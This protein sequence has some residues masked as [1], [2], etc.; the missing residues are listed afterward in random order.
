MPLKQEELGVLLLSI[1]Y[2]SPANDKIF[3]LLF[4]DEITA[5]IA[6]AQLTGFSPVPCYEFR[7]FYN[8]ELPVPIGTPQHRALLRRFGCMWRWEEAEDAQQE[9]A[10][11]LREG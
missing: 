8:H 4:D 3:E 2:P 1:K 10:W 11:Y 7:W 5:S 6:L 9:E